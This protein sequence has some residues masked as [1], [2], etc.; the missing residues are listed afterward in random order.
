MTRQRWR[1]AGAGL[2]LSFM[3]WSL[4]ARAAPNPLCPG[5]CDGGSQACGAASDCEGAPCL[6]EAS[7]LDGHGALTPLIARVV[8]EGPGG[9]NDPRVG[10]SCGLLTCEPTAEHLAVRSTWGSGAGAVKDIALSPGRYLLIADLAAENRT[11]GALSIVAGGLEAWSEPVVGTSGASAPFEWQRAAVFFEVPAAHSG[12]IQVRLHGEGPGQVGLRRVVVVQLATFGAYVRVKAGDL[13]PTGLA[14]LSARVPNAEGGRRVGCVDASC[15]AGAA[16]GGHSAWLDLGALAASLHDVAP[17][18][19]SDRRSPA[20]RMTVSFQVEA[21][22]RDGCAPRA[23]P[24]ELTFEL[25]W[26]PDPAAIVWRGTKVVDPSRVGLVVPHAPTPIHPYALTAAFLQ[27]LLTA[28]RQAS[29]PTPSPTH[30]LRLGASTAHLDPYDAGPVD[31]LA[32][33]VLTAMGLNVAGWFESAP[34]LATRQAAAQDGLAHRLLEVPDV[35]A[36]YEGDFDLTTIAAHVRDALALDRSPLGADLLGCTPETCIARLRHAPRV[37][38]G[39][40]YRE[41]FITWLE[42]RGDPAD[43]LGLASFDDAM[44]LDAWPPGPAPEGPAALRLHLRQVEF[45]YTASA[46]ALSEV[47]AALHSRVAIPAGLELASMP[48][49]ALRI[50]FDEA[51]LSALFFRSATGPADD[52][53]VS[54]IGANA[55]LAASIAAPWREAAE[56]RGEDFVIA[57]FVER[58][59]AELPQVLVDHAARG[60]TW[61][62][63][64]AYGPSDASLTRAHGGL[65]ERGR[66]WMSRVLEANQAL[67]S[68]EPWFEVTR[69]PLVPSVILAAESDGLI[70]APSDASLAPLDND[71]LGWHAALT[72]ASR[73]VEFMLESDI[74]QGFLEHPVT[75]RRLL[76]VTRKHVSRQAWSAIERWVEAGNTLVLGPEL[77]AYDED[78]Q[79]APERTAWLGAVVGEARRGGTSLR[80][81]GALGV[82]SVLV[83]GEWR[84][85]LALIGTPIALSTDDRPVVVR[86]PRGRGRVIVS[87]VP[88]G[89]IYRQ[90]ESGCEPR[91]PLELPRYTRDYSAV[92]REAMAV[93][94]P[95]SSTAP[96]IDPRVSVTRLATDSGRPFVLVVP[97]L[98]SP[99]PVSIH[100]SEVAGCASVREEIEGV[101]LP[102]T[103]G[104]LFATLSGPAILTWDEGG[105]AAVVEEQQAEVAEA[106][107]DTT[108]DR[109]EGCLGGESNHLF[110]WLIMAFIA[111]RRRRG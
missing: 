70:P 94:A 101:D 71:A 20:N 8:P 106:E 52:C 10:W 65:G 110:L 84:E 12:P 6:F 83:P 16:D 100:L 15:R 29:A 42:A 43:S 68:F 98:G 79:L 56:A 92:L 97:W 34:S 76:V 87:G 74:A 107:P 91:R 80:W 32:H 66:A 49:A 2:L 111:P 5:L 37:F 18:A 69:R 77:A 85:V 41:A 109:D 95:S 81:S 64:E 86:V 78:G 102:V 28:D 3:F 39:E 14:A 51:K 59:R 103:F 82:S 67:G 30:S 17:K 45:A 4:A 31:P 19:A 1:G 13:A 25:A 21:C 63:H 90:A 9:L 105:C 22:G 96:S 104:S 73:P 57:A 23:E 27:D 61:F 33:Q 44:P 54:R 99:E 47:R 62:I 48:L 26:A 38:D 24:V 72:H 88:L 60:V 89:A 7:C 46:Q 108:R 58:G 53:E 50:A 55:Q 36:T 75:T 35:L 40:A 93:F 11:W